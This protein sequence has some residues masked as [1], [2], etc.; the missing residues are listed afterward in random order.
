MVPCIGEVSASPLA[1]AP[2]FFRLRACGFFAA[3]GT[4]C[5]AGPAARPGGQH[6]LE[7]AAAHLDGDGLPLRGL[8]GLARRRRTARCWLSNSVSIQL[9]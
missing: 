1:A 8:D 7:P 4:G 3:A 9:V 2:V 6:D 5:A